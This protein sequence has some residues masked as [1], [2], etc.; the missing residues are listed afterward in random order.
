MLLTDKIE[1][2]S[3]ENIQSE[4]QNKTDNDYDR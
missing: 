4:P 1:E 2:K 3:K